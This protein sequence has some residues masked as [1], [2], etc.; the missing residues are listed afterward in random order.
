M[1]TARWA[2]GVVLFVLATGCAAPK[3]PASSLKVQVLSSNPARITGG[4]ALIEVL[5]RA[6]EP[7]SAPRVRAN[8]VDV[9]NAFKQAPQAGRFLGVV[10]GLHLGRNTLEA[11]WGGDTAVL[12]LTNYP[13]TG[14]VFAGPKEQPFHCETTRFLLP[15]GGNL[16]APMDA[17]C[18]VETIVVHVYKPSDGGPFKRLPDVTE[19]PTDVAQ[20]TTT[21]GVSVPY[22][23]RVEIGTIDR[24]I[25]QI[26]VLHD[27]T[28][29]LPPS[30]TAAPRAWNERMV[31]L[32]GG[33]CGGMY[34]QGA[35]TEN[36]LSEQFIGLG[37]LTVSNSLNVFANNCD[38]LLAAESM[39]MTRERAIERVGPPLFTMG[40][41]CSGGA[42]QVL[43][44][45]DNYPGLLDGIMPLCNSVDFFR[46]GQ[47]TSDIRLLY[48]W[49]ETPAGR[50]LTDEQKEAITGTPLNADPG[51]WKLYFA[52]ACPDVIPDS[53]AF[54]PVRHPGGIRCSQGDHL[55]NSL[56]RDPQTGGARTTLDNVGVQYG[57]RALQAGI[58]SIEQ[59]LDLNE[60]I[61][62][63]D[64]NGVRSK[65]RSVADP[66]GVAAAYRS[67]R[68]LHAGGGLKD[69]P[70]V[71]IRNYSD[72]DGPATPGN[73]GLGATHLKYGTYA[74]MSRLQ[75]ETGSRANYV[76]L[77]ESHRNGLYSASS[78]SGDEVSRYAIARMDDWLTA[79][80]RDASTDP[81]HV[82]VVRAKPLDLT[83]S[84]F[85]LEGRRIVEAQTIAGGRCNE[86]YPT[87]APPRVV[88]GGP[89][90]SDVLKC[91]LKPIAMGEYPV[92][93][94][95][96]QRLRLQNIFPEGV[97]D[98]SRPG[99]GQAAPAG[100]WQSF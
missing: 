62:G 97:C 21:L 61:G 67:G 36:V 71:E 99:M 10:P 63:Y 85:D 24:G 11:S 34:R 48:D 88:A 44:I 100:P 35:R 29:E 55:V 59:F 89:M 7:G 69:I 82:K 96:A 64:R 94:T 65:E 78:S 4:D 72:A 15:G 93:L 16:P 51:A 33:G 23:V 53:A 92:S 49:F 86:L 47:H 25:Y 57:L 68:V 39:M 32:F 77:L 8:G 90:S 95:R 80:A 22:V 74:F 81:R 19:L 84:C 52:G 58:I 70:I 18:S 38:D 98:W 26:A 76:V 1:N 5:G 20:T 41:G 2:F 46:L 83:D 54:H 42:H 6:A 30:P 17:H 9:S 12:S 60:Q 87:H 66:L 45:A 28:R 56:G 3:A 50:V 79:V 14:P 31:Y 75:R 43:L 37:Y 40:W 91:R 13:I 27:P 73:R